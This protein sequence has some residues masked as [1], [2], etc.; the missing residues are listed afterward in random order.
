VAA[1]SSGYQPR[2]TPAERRAFFDLE[3]RIAALEAATAPAVDWTEGYPTY[4]DRY[5]DETGDAMTG[6]LT[7]TDAPPNNV[8]LRLLSGPAANASLYFRDGAN[9]ANNARLTGFDLAASGVELAT[10]RTNAPIKCLVNNLEKLTVHHDHVVTTVPVALPANPAVALHAAPKQYVDALAPVNR[11][12]TPSWT[13]MNPGT[14]GTVAAHW[15]EIPLLGT[16]KIVVV[17]TV[18]VTMGTSPTLADV[19]VA[20]P[21]TPWST[22]RFTGSGFFQVASFR[23][24]ATWFTIGP[25]ATGALV[26]PHRYNSAVAVTNGVVDIGGF[27]LGSVATWG[28]GHFFSLDA[29][30][31]ADS[32]IP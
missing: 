9:A 18:D 26:R 27:A 3:R 29:T 10:E 4:D 23:G 16:T 6:R 17:L 7:I 32:A 19:S 21:R 12:W 11:A 24:P 20:L 22:Q 25:G 1:P 28:P 5:V 14:G 8:P 30:Y 15:V 31:I 13:N 2:T